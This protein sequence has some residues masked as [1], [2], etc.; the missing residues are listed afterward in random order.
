VRISRSFIQRAAT[1]P[2]M[3]DQSST[4]I[5]AAPVDP[6]TPKLNFD[7]LS[8]IFGLVDVSP[9]TLVHVDRL[10]RTIAF[11]IPHLWSSIRVTGIRAFD[12]RYIEGKEICNT[13]TR[14]EAA[15]KRAGN[16]PLYLDLDLFID[17]LNEA[18]QNMLR[19]MIP[20]IVRRKEHWRYVECQTRCYP[21]KES[22]LFSGPFPMLWAIEWKGVPI[23]NAF[24]PSQGYER[25]PPWKLLAL[26]LQD[27]PVLGSAVFHG[28]ATNLIEKFDG[29]VNLNRLQ[30]RQ[31][32]FTM[33]LNFPKLTEMQLINL[34][35]DWTPGNQ[36][37]RPVTAPQLTSF[38]MDGCDATVL[39][40]IKMPNL[41]HLTI[42][43]ET[44]GSTT[45]ERNLSA[46]LE[47][48]WTGEYHGSFAA[49]SLRSL[50]LRDQKISTE[51]V[52][53]FL[54]T[55]PELDYLE[56]V[57]PKS[58]GPGLFQ[59]MASEHLC[60]TLAELHLEFH[61]TYVPRGLPMDE[62]AIWSIYKLLSGRRNSG[63]RRA[64]YRFHK[65]SELAPPMRDI[66]LDGPVHD[67]T[68]WPMDGEM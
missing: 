12:T 37:D 50:Q 7:V 66:F 13:P 34:T 41:R 9:W 47:R 44:N 19:A 45:R 36:S 1:S 51:D 58:V 59:M 49:P 62:G 28:L 22:G 43:G 30:L 40:R 14:L 65:H 61:P 31:S 29:F 52:L 42:C 35:C 46:V 5:F 54:R 27:S 25:C 56:L 17:G 60:P 63:I 48:T 38:V 68:V 20:I 23:L 26:V 15:L 3:N 21:W 33:H 8:T 10:W 18:S 32:S 6:I 39:N 2:K 16:T 64:M 4:C 53:R 24:E 55:S 67:P 57:Y 11:G